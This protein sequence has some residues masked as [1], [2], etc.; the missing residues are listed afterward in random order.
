M[1]NSLSNNRAA[2]LVAGLIAGLGVA[3]FWPHEPAYASTAD[4][5]G[6]FALITVP[7]GTNAAGFNDP[8][9][10]V[11]I[12]DFLT[13][14]LKGAVLNRQTGLFTSFY[15]RDLAKDFEVDPAAAPHYAVAS[16]NAQMANQGGIT[17]AS[18]VVYVAELSSGKLAS[19][20]FPWTEVPRA[21]QQV[22]QMTPTD[23]YQWRPPKKKGK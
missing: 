17:Y 20:A 9:E 10:G 14:Q 11:F 18:G 19:Y 5:D 4:R 21:G 8:M 1:R 16:G 7:V 3:Y 12:L 15:Q 6:S 22:T 13:G 2:W 23:V